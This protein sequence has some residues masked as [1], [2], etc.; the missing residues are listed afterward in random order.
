MTF[1]N[2][3]FPEP[4]APKIAV[5]SPS[6]MSKLIPFNTANGFFTSP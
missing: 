6:L 3:D 5:N 2:V 4:D 1:K